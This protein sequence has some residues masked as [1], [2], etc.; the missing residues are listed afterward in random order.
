MNGTK[1]AD[2]IVVATHVNRH[3]NWFIRWCVMCVFVTAVFVTMYTVYR[4]SADVETLVFVTSV[5]KLDLDGYEV[6]C[7]DR[8]LPAVLC[9]VVWS[10]RLRV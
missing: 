5:S 8:H 3:I 7:T 1:H 4:L 9:C 2:C 10:R 6:V